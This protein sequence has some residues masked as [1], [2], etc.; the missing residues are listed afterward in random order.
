MVFIINVYLHLIRVVFI[1]C[2]WI[3]P[4]Y[5]KCVKRS[6][7]RRRASIAAHLSFLPAFLPLSLLSRFLL[8]LDIGHAVGISA[9]RNMNGDAGMEPSEM[10]GHLPPTHNRG[11]AL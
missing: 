3:I 5:G 10:P 1:K 9:Q 8:V 6:L 2:A 11:Q 7:C 4:L